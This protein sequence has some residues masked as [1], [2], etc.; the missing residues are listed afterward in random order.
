MVGFLRFLLILAGILALVVL[1]IALLTPAMD[2]W[3]ATTDEISATYPGDELV[4]DPA[5]M[6]NRAVTIQATPE[7]IYPWIIQ[8]GADKAGMYSYTWLENLIHC[9]QSN[10]DRLH[11]EWQNLQVGDLVRMCPQG[12]GPVPFTVALLNPPSAIV[13]GHQEN[14]AWTDVW[15]FIIEPLPDGASRLILRTRTNLT[16]GIWTIIHPGIFIMERAML[17]GIKARVEAPQ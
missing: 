13:M 14:G 15:Q 3:G 17:V 4:P 12:Y 1:V 5:S 10:A 16:G 6:V 7:Q 2:R 9:Y 8:L 11:P